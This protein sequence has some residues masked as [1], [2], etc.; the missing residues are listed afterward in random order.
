MNHSRKLSEVFI[1]I[2]PQVI[3]MHF[4]NL[5][6]VVVLVVVCG[7]KRVL[8][9]LGGVRIFVLI[10]H[11][12]ARIHFSNLKVVVVCRPRKGLKI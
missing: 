9:R 5:K 4:S 1:L 10:I 8:R 7:S 3:R 6:V 2:I 12:V 11:Q